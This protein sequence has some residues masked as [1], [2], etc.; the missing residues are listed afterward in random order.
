MRRM[1]RVGIEGKGES[2]W[3]AWFLI[4]TLRKFAAHADRRGDATVRDEMLAKADEY[5][6]AVDRS[7]WDGEWY[8]RAYFDDGSP[9]GAPGLVQGDTRFGDI[10]IAAAPLPGTSIAVGSPYLL[11][12]ST[13]SGDIVLN[14]N[15]FDSR[16]FRERVDTLRQAGYLEYD[17]KGKFYYLTPEGWK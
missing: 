13:W 7:A 2:V 9:L 11:S 5:A 10:R 17:A 4:A 15:K 6:E 14:S 12:G 16:V 1:N 3:L 8:R